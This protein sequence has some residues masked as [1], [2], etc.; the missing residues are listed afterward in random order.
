M[1]PY[2]ALRVGLA[3]ASLLGNKRATRAARTASQQQLD[4]SLG[5]LQSGYGGIQSNLTN[6]QN[7][8]TGMIPQMANPMYTGGF[9]SPQAYMGGVPGQQYP[10]VPA[11]QGVPTGAAGVTDM[12]YGP[13]GNAGDVGGAKGVA[14]VAP[15]LRDPG[16]IEFNPLMPRGMRDKIRGKVGEKNAVKQ[17]AYDEQMAQYNAAQEAAPVMSSGQSGQPGGPPIPNYGQDVV[18]ALKAR[19]TQAIADLETRRTNVMGELEGIG[20]QGRKDINE[21]YGN[22]ITQNNQGMVDSGLYGSTVNATLNTGINRERAGSLSRL[23]ENIGQMRA[24]YESALS[25]DIANVRAATSADQISAMD[26]QRREYQA[27]MQGIPAGYIDTMNMYAGLRNSNIS[28]FT[29]NAA[30]MISGVNIGYP[31]QNQ[32]LASLANMGN[33]SGLAQYR[34]YLESQQSIFGG[35]GGSMFGGLGLATGALLAAP[36]GGMSMLGGAMIGGG[37]GYGVGTGIDRPW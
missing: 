16:S 14:P 8:V 36:T 25:G 12:R 5:L 27:A 11:T 34:K 23:N 22:A 31:D 29:T 9:Y 20:T 37:L 18:D 32:V 24:G 4:T 15:N 26:Q 33:A 3:G 7:Y 13:Q 30:N 28:N 21:A 1:N 19:Q 6:A 2:T 17:T 35:S 10:S